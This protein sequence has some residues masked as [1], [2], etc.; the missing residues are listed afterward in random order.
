[1]QQEI[2]QETR[3]LEVEKINRELS[4]WDQG[5]GMKKEK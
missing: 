1:M 4:E 5:G 3:R 2:D